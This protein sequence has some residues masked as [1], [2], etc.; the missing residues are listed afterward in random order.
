[1]KKHFSEIVFHRRGLTYFVPQQ[2]CYQLQVKSSISSY[3]RWLFCHAMK[4]TI[5]QR[6]K[7][8][9]RH[10]ELK[11]AAFLIKRAA[12]SQ[13]VSIQQW[14]ISP[15]GR[16]S[17]I[18]GN[19]DCGFKIFAQRQFLYGIQSAF[20][21]SSVAN[22]TLRWPA[23]SVPG[24]MENELYLMRHSVSDESKT[25][26][27]FENNENNLSPPSTPMPTHIH[28]HTKCFCVHLRRIVGTKYKRCRRLSPPSI[29]KIKFPPPF[30]Y[31]AR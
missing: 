19:Y 10:L 8:T 26:Y 30:I 21:H 4:E 28:I 22:C 7:E 3:N 13:R 23:E 1:M 18:R 15:K 31:H 29:H 24:S 2:V 11:L 12:D 14:K 5:W 9:R 6:N 17:V 25:I 27:T 20:K 16:K